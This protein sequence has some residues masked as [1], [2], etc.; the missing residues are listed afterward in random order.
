MKL[1]GKAASNRLALTLIFLHVILLIYSTSGF[2]SKFAARETFMSTGFIAW[3]AGML[4]VLAVYAVGWQ[5]ILKWLPLTVAFANKAITVVW[6]MFWGLLL[7]G[8]QITLYKII[9]AIVVIAGIVLFAIA[10]GQE[11][12]QKQAE[13]L[14]E[15][16]NDSLEV[17]PGDAEA[18]A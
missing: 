2:M 17:S 1:L 12:A 5:Q 16:A 8:E 14:D 7:F 11:R 15:I 6:G 3:Y 13:T 18:D 9:G 10:D 4:G